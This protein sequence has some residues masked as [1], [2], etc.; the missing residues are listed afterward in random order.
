MTHVFTAVV[1][2]FDYTLADS[3]RGAIECIKF[4]FETMELSPISSEA[5]CRT[6]GL[7]LNDTLL[8]LAGDDA[9]HRRAEFSKLFV[10]RAD[11]VMVDLTVLYPS[12]RPAIAALSQ[13]GLKLGIV[14]T[15][16]RYRI[17]EILRRESLVQDF[18]VVIGG[19]DVEQHKPH[20]EGLMKAME[21]LQC[22]PASLVYVGDS[23]T[24]AELA[25]RAAV[26]FVAV[27]SGVTPLEDFKPYNPLHILQSLTDL[28][29]V[30][31][32]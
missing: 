17:E 5:A 12:V 9:A 3:S 23:V 14:S 24:D 1:F 31:S 29:G 21:T 19:E 13:R 27:L 6:I 22:S 15:K 30:L 8:S 4:A 16:F 32:P 26:P 28:P 25:K 7:S 11:E 2:D 20:P 18:H 10:Q